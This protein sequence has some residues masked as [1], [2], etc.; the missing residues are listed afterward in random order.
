MKVLKKTFI[1]IAL[2]GAALVSYAADVKP[3]VEADALPDALNYYPA[4]PDTMSPQFMY[5]ISQYMW[6][7]TMR[8]DSARAALAVAQA[9]ETIEE[10]A[11]M[12][13]EPF[14]ME[15]SAKKTPAIMNVLE[16]GIRTLKQVGSKAKR[17]YMRRRPYDRFNE[18]TLV[19]AEEERLRTNGSYPS[20]HTIRAWSMAMLL[21]EVNP[22]AQDALLKYAYEW[23]Q[24]RVIAGFHWQSDVDASKV[25]VSGAYP[26]LHTNEIFMADMR[27]AQAEFKKL[28]AA[29][30]KAAAGKAGKK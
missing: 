18:P 22:A 15:I 1:A 28:N 16:R 26:S 12:F 25:L 14:G 20:G 9:V 5:D 13:S 7:K 30:G 27:K 4:P 23:G 2:F 21:I 3:Y 29:A 11:A 17:H 19:P 8:L 10:M 24:S 6:G